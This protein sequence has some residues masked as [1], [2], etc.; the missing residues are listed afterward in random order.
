VDSSQI[1]IRLFPIR[2]RHCSKF[3]PKDVLT[4]EKSAKKLNPLIKPLPSFDEAVLRAEP[5]LPA[6]RA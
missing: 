5:R 6:D 3:D 4:T 2:T 1:A